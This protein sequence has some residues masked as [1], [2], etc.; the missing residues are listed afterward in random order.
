M[1]ST[2]IRFLLINCPA[3]PA[4]TLR[5]RPK[6]RRITRFTGITTIRPYSPDF[7]RSP[8]TPRQDFAVSSGHSVARGL[9][10]TSQQSFEFQVRHV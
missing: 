7:T 2:S 6:E 1:I 3:I 4:P 5:N 10:S 9:P 8:L